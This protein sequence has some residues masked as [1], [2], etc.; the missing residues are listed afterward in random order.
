MTGANDLPAHLTIILR[1]TAHL[2]ANAPA[3]AAFV[4]AAATWENQ[5]LSPVT[6]YIDADFGPDNFGTPWGV[7]ILGSTSSPSISSVPYSQVRANLISSASTP[8]ETTAYN[9]LPATQIP[10][11]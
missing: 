10:T 6:I 9:A 8:A 7:N 4:R 2:D 3:K 1:A 11:D 5:I